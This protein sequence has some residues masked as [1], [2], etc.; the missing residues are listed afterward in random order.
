[1]PRF[2]EHGSNAA[3]ARI[4]QFAPRKPWDRFIRDTFKPE[5]GEHTAIIGPTGQGKTTLQNA[6]LPVFPFV[7]VFATKPM[8]F[9]MDRL[10]HEDGY[11][12][13]ARWHRLNPID[14]PR[15]VVWPDASDVDSTRLQ[16]DVFADAFTKIFREVGRPKHAP[17][18]WAVAVDELWYVVNFLPPTTRGGTTM[19]MYIKLY[20]LQGR[21]LGHSLILATQRPASVPVE[22]YDQCTHLFF[23]R[24]ND[25]ANLDR[26]A[27]INSR[28]S[29]L[30]RY[31]IQNLEK[32][33]ALYLNT[34]TGEMVRTRAPVP[35]EY[36]PARTR[37]IAGPMGAGGV[38]IGSAHSA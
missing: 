27:G 22:V 36:Q 6:I 32:Y 8:D 30:T 35:R 7:A 2:P 14:H 3:S 38:E 9:T 11:L 5:P 12:R 24:D 21:A 34:R 23:L 31:I 25:D 15:R 13:L 33:Q 26:L 19:A 4:A 18:G 28:D 1:M 20:L 16:Y 29:G 17:V 37:G 10:I